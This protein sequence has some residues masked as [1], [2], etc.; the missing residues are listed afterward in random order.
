MLLCAHIDTVPLTAP[1]D[2]VLVDGGWENAG[3]G[4][5][6]ADNKAAVAVILGVARRAAER[7]CPVN[8]EL[9]FT[10]GEETALAGARAF[11]VDQ[12]ACT[13][14]Y[15]FDHASP[16]GEVIVASPTQYRIDASFKGLAAHAGISPELGRSAIVA[17]ARAVSAM[18]LGRLDEQTTANVGEISGGTAMNVVPERCDL[19]AE[20]RSLDAER[21]ERVVAEMVDHLHDAANLPDCECDLDVGVQKMFTGY[22]VTPSAAPVA[23]AE[24]AL[25]EC[26]YEPT[27]VASGGAS[28]ANVFQAHG[29]S[30]INLANGTER[31]HQATERVSVEALEAMLDVALTL[32]ERAGGD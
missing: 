11:D 13:F 7:G 24:T 21:V 20:A 30:I 9:L 28:D 5:L 19:V 27:R 16:I 8:L 12:L 4:I 32:V 2:P 17:A 22:R 26:G 14:G 3:P 1:L 6:G 18:S 10:I 25:R 29:L 31:P 15:V 23:V